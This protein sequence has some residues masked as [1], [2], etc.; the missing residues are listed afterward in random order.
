MA[1]WRRS[2]ASTS[3]SSARSWRRCCW[4]SRLIKRELP[5]YNIQL[6]YYEHYPFIKVDI[7]TPYP[8]VYATRAILDDGA[9][10]FGPFRNANAVATTIE[11]ITDLFPVRTCTVKVTD[12]AKRW[13]P[14][15]RLDF[16][17]CL[18]PCVGKTDVATYRALIDDILAYLDG[19]REPLVNRLWERLRAASD[20][21][22]FERAARLR[23]AIRQVNEVTIGQSLLTAA[24]ERTHLLIALP[25]AEPGAR[26]L[27]LILAGRLA[28]QAR[29][30]ADEPAVDAAR[31][32]NARL[33]GGGGTHRP[34]PAG[35]PGG[36]R[37][38]RDHQP[39]A[40][41][42]P[43]Q[44]VDRAA[45]GRPS[46]RGWLAGRRR[47][48]ASRPP[49]WRCGRLAGSR[50]SRSKWSSTCSIASP[51]TSDQPAPAAC[52]NRAMT[53][54]TA[55]SAAARLPAILAAL[56]EAYGRPEWRPTGEPLAELIQTILSQHTSDI[57][58][59]RAYRSLMAR[60][61]DFAAVR[62]AP[63]AEVADAIRS[64]GLAEIKAQRIQAALRALSA[65]GEPPRCPTWRRCRWTRRGA[66]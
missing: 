52:Y 11:L 4:S 50:P 9:R 58:S 35:R 5:Q 15:L 55:T 36:R 31:A 21:L 8:R 66:I 30:A 19:R 32:L 37:R 42:E 46:R 45:A 65:D 16:G 38:D 1:C 48:P 27:L 34:R 18:G 43:G 33:G 64:G 51:P 20:R 56:E 24:V 47:A 3:R 60:F 6:R 23:D 39:L 25:S 62:D 40:P 17:Q 44:S 63:H 49:R 14:C 41:P 57:N 7:Q 13:R 2:S 22:D 29:V 12:P 28:A 26:E 54:A 53:T 10:Y 59:G 61:P